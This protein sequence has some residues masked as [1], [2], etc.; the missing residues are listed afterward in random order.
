MFSLAAGTREISLS[1]PRGAVAPRLAVSS[2]ELVPAAAAEAIAAEAERAAES[3]PSADWF[4][5]AGYG[6][7][8]HWTSK[9]YPRR[10]PLRPYREAVEAF[11]VD[12]LA[13]IAAEAGA[14]YVMFTANHAEPSFPGP[15]HSWEAMYPGWSTE[16]DLVAEL[17][18]A[19]SRRR[20]RLFLYLNPFAAYIRSGR[21][22]NVDGSTE[23]NNGVRMRGD[24]REDYLGTTCE[25]L[26]EIGT[27]YRT[28][29]AG[30]WFDSWYQP[31]MHFGHFPMEPVYRA[32]KAGNSDRLCAFNWWIL[33][34]GT[35]WQDYWAGES[36]GIGADPEERYPDYGPGRGLQRHALLIMDDPWVHEKPNTP[37][38]PPALET[39]E[40]V[41]FVRRN[42]EFGGVVTV[43]LGIY[44]DGGVASE[45]LAVMRAVQKAVRS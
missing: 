29:L 16:R 17:A 36:G 30:Y 20:V 6:L 35:P 34:N 23:F 21:V 4:A 2:L 32:A 40:L 42:H 22:R 18:T 15:V 28:D 11:D 25:L 41:R 19:L 39:D 10:G 1:V 33:P 45:S 7:M 14:G 43:N 8:F 5:H 12:E 26:T 31:F 3:R 37:V 9:S 13:D 38:A 24:C 44:Q 27:R